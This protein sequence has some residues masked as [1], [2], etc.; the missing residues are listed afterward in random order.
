VSSYNRCVTPVLAVA[1]SQAPIVRARAESKNVPVTLV[2]VGP[3][4]KLAE[5]AGKVDAVLSTNIPGPQLRQLLRDH[6]SVRWV[7]AQSAGVD[8]VMLPEVTGGRITVTRVRHVHDVF[9]AEFC[10]ALILG[11]S[12][13]LRDIVLANERREW[14]TFQPQTLVGKTLSIIGYG[15]IGLALARRAKPFDMRIVG[16]RSRPQSDGV[17]DEVWGED[18]TDDALREA[19][20]VALLVPG[21]AHRKHLMDERRLRLLGK[22][23]YLINAGRGEIVDEAALER[24][25]REEGFAG[26]L[27]DT[28]EVEPLPKD[29]PLWTNPRVLVTDHLAGLRAAPLMDEVMDQIVENIARFGRGEPLMN[30]VDVSRG[31]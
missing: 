1:E 9:V 13:G 19:D 12:K 11:A 30:E 16:V 23:A 15:E 5:A 4:G 8:G 26:A 25:L 29:S 17:A 10:M 21:G 6:G 18:R 27:I 3:D 20:Y 31:Y 28:F 24:V 22:G 14:L 2:T 7:A